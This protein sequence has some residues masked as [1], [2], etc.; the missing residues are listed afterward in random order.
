MRDSTLLPLEGGQEAHLPCKEVELNATRLSLRSFGVV[1]PCYIAS[2]MFGFTKAR[3][4][5]LGKIGLYPLQL[6]CSLS[7]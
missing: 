2:F 5:E 3:F 6:L 4:L 7:E 1:L